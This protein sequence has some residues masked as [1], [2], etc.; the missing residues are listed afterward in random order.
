M[1]LLIIILIVLLLFSSLFSGTETAITTI[2]PIKARSIAEQNLRGSAHLLW[3]KEHTRQVLIAI[4]FGNNLVNIAAASLTT[5]V[6]TDLFGSRGVGYATGVVT[7]LI[8][9]FGEITPKSLATQH[10]EV[11]ARYASP[12][13]R[14][15]TIVLSPVILLLQRL[16]DLITNL[17]KSQGSNLLTEE[18]FRTVL[19]LSK[20]E[21]LVAP[22]VVSMMEHLMAFESKKITSIMT[23]KT[24]IEYLDGN[25]LLN[26]CIDKI[27]H[28][29]HDQFPVFQG[30]PE[31]IIGMLYDS[32]V[33]RYMNQTRS[34]AQ[35]RDYM[36]D[37]SFVPGTKDI[38][39]VLLIFKRK[40]LTIAMIIDEYGSI[41]GLVTVEDILAQIAG[42]ASE[43]Y[44]QSR[45][46]VK[47]QAD[48]SL[49]VDAA[50]KI[51]RFQKLIHRPIH[52]DGFNTISG[53][54]QY[55][56]ERIPQKNEEVIVDGIRMRIHEATTKQ[57]RKVKVLSY[58]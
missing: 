40:K 23:P 5:K 10:A 24:E 25:A 58:A 37:V 42:D 22:D 45:K 41:I 34:Q 33:L 28:S 18:E 21:G 3:V 51:E 6:F 55:N 20:E 4:L 8:L 11:I 54:I 26:E 32:D 13:L 39:E 36:R 46:R 19:S 17:F 57:I 50:M 29:D 7:F 56:L 53:W 38:D 14:Y 9:V 2:N 43:V 15:L 52:Q 35:V 12:P 31:S 47:L 16:S 49:M 44:A 27:I 30:S 48:G 1:T